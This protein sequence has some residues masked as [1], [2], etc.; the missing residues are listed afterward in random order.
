MGQDWQLAD[1]ARAHSQDMLLNDFFEHENLSGQTAV[2]RGN[3]FGYT[4][5]KNFG[6]FFTEGISENIF[7]GYLYSSFNAQRWNYLALEE[8]AFKVVDDWMNSPGLRENILA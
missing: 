5:A 8:P 1:I 7:Q 3:D 2:Y 4:C 6:D